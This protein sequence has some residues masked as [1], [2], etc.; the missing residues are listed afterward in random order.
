MI[1]H[2]APGDGVRWCTTCGRRTALDDWGVCARCTALIIRAVEKFRPGLH[3]DLAKMELFEAYAHD[4]R[5]RRLAL[6][7]GLVVE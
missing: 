6:A 4:R 3:I 7:R 1:H 2:N 5:T